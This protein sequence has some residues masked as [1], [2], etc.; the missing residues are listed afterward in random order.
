MTTEELKQLAVNLEGAAKDVYEYRNR[1]HQVAE[2]ILKKLGSNSDFSDAHDA[3]RAASKKL[4]QAM[5]QSMIEG[6]WT[7]K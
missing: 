6:V 7:S 3:R 2:D 1:L 5:Y 4:E